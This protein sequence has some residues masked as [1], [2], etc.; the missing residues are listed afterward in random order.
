MKTR[1]CFCIGLLLLFGVVGAAR[2]QN[3]I[4][5]GHVSGS[6]GKPLKA[7]E[8]IA[9]R[10][11]A[12]AAPVSLRTDARG[13]FVAGTLPAGTYRIK[14]KVNDEDVFGADKLKT[15]PGDPLRI[16]YDMRH[17]VVTM[18]NATSKKMRRFAWQEAATG[19]HTDG[20]WVETYGVDGYEAPSARTERK[21]GRAMKHIQDMS[22][23]G[24][25]PH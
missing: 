7:A 24:A 17:A 23:V 21:D 16:D 4:I 15:R 18:S 6:D 10:Q 25:I 3:S 2:G 22:G 14:I 9:E 11:D 20:R 1:S 12:R 19:S 5:Q 13:D 8:I